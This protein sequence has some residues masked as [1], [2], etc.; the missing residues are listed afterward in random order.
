MKPSPSILVVED[1]KDI[2]TCLTEVLTGLGYEVVVATNGAEALALLARLSVPDAILLDIRMPVMDGW[3]F[4]GLQLMDPDIAN[5]PTI[6]LSASLVA[7]VDEGDPKL[8]DVLQKPV[9]IEE[10]AASLARAL[11]SAEPLLS[12]PS[13][14]LESGRALAS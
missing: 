8:A 5:I 10:L 6:V 7:E 12:L 13:R 14:S 3:T 4:R 9:G 2:R 1:D 11:S